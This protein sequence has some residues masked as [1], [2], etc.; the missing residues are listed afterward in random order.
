MRALATA[1]S[2]PRHREDP[3]LAALDPSTRRRVGE[4]WRSR[5]ASELRAGSGFAQ[6]VVGLYAIG[7]HP[8]VLALA[9]RAAHEETEHAQSCH[10]LAELYLDVPL[11]FPRAELAP[12]PPHRGATDALR[13]TLHVIGLSCINETI[14]CEFVATCLDVSEASAVREACARHLR[15]EIGHARVGWAHLASGVLDAQDRAQVASWLPR[16]VQANARHWLA[17][18][19]TLPPEGV[20]KHGYPALAALDA[21]VGRALREV[22]LPGF[23]HVGIDV[24]RATRDAAAIDGSR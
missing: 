23:A 24:S 20:P 18:M 7:A 16:L 1:L 5:A 9:T 19:R 11:R 13:A 22:V 12:M 15:D 6:A 21:A 17:R 3:L 8:D 2:D 14:A 4:I 10:A